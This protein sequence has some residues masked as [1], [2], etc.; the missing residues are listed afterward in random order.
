V[1]TFANLQDE[2]LRYLYGYGLSQPRATRLTAG[3]S[4]S[5]T[6]F[7]VSSAAD[8]EQGVAEV[9]SELVFIESVDRGSNIATVIRGYL[10]TTAATHAA[11]AVLTMAPTWPRS[12]VGRAINDVI[13]SLYP[14]LFGV[15][16]T[17]FT[18]T[19]SVTTYA[20]PADAER[21]LKVTADLNGPSLEQ[22]MVRRFD[23]NSVAPTDD[24]PNTNT[25]TLMESVS[26][27]RTVTVTYQK[28]LTELVND[29]D[30]ITVSGL[31]ETAKLAV[32]YGACAQ[33]LSFMDASRLPVDS[34]QADEYDTKNQIGMAT[35]I[36]GQMRAYQALEVE[37]ERQRL[38]AAT[39]VAIRMRTR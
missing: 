34:A 1:T 12:S 4:N 22:Q 6:A 20:L 26:P 10:G 8:L 35:R 2:V 15:A 32:I 38:R 9:D 37:A 7:S 21:V 31:R 29:S 36:A 19:P 24:W 14:T 27:G 16:Q 28:A 25:I 30:A 3:V 17:Q 23:F 13:L 33:L 5:V 39:P 11:N 18:F